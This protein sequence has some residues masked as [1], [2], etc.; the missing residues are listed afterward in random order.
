MEVNG[1]YKRE[2]VVCTAAHKCGKWDSDL[3]N[4]PE[5]P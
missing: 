4:E 3:K 5:F 1:K 2:I